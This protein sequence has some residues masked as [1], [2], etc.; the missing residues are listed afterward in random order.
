MWLK[1][2]INFLSKSSD[3]IFEAYYLKNIFHIYV[4][5]MNKKRLKMWY[6]EK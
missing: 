5:N 1:Y 6:F 4:S 2:N 3:T